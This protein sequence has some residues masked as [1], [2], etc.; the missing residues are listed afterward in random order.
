MTTHL[1][2]AAEAV[3]ALAPADEAQQQSAAVESDAPAAAAASHDDLAPLEP[4]SAADVFAARQ[5]LADRIRGSK[6]LPKGLRERLCQA[7]ETVQLSGDAAAEAML[8]I[9]DAVE[10]IEAAVPAHWALTD[11]SLE[12]PTHPQGEG[13]FQTAGDQLSDDD[14]ARIAAEQ[15]AATGFGPR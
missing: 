6:R 5:R 8:P 13:F 12:S 9:A 15:L 3:D 1:D 7:V 4:T 10:L 14:A 11:D 2:P